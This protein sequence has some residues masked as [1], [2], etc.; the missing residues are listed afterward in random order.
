M[1]VNDECCLQ[2]FPS[3]KTNFI[4]II[5]VVVMGV[6][7][8]AAISFFVYLRKRRK[9]RNA[10]KNLKV[11]S[12][13]SKPVVEYYDSNRV[14]SFKGP[15]V[16]RESEQDYSVTDSS[17][18]NSVSNIAIDT[19]K[20][21]VNID[22]LPEGSYK[23]KVAFPYSATMVDE[24]TLVVGDVLYLVHTFNDGWAYGINIESKQQGVFPKVCTKELPRVENVID[25]TVIE[26][27]I[28]NDEIVDK[29]FE[30]RLSSLQP[31][32]I[33]RPEDRT[34]VPFSL[35]LSQLDDVADEENKE[36]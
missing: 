36:S 7:A 26:N 34:R 9:A 4:I 13:F 12:D 18:L 15:L 10:E 19:F 23:V 25:E 22:S 29:N 3:S 35:Y 33:Y 30:K 6:I 8:V 21:P 24:L 11:K 32:E 17:A 27:E 16:S 14:V 31:N 20:S 28:I 1:L 2:K 5:T